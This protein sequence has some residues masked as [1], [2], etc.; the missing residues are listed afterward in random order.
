MKTSLK[1][2][3]TI[4]SEK[5]AVVKAVL[6]QNGICDDFLYLTKRGHRKNARFLQEPH[7]QSTKYRLNARM[8]FRARMNEISMKDHKPVPHTI[9]QEAKELKEKEEKK[10]E[11]EEEE[12]GKE[13]K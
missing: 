3:P 6:N 4:I 12:K 1:T 8:V 9:I 10:E 7:V 13:G 2:N 5:C 11:E